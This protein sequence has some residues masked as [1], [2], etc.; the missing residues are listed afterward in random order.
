MREVRESEKITDFITVHK[1]I[2]KFIY[3]IVAKV[4][5]IELVCTEGM[6]YAALGFSTIL[7]IRFF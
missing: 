5:I 2:L 4:F 3:S 1:N 7:A 6:P